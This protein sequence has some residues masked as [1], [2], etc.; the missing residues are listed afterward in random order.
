MAVKNEC[1]QRRTNNCSRTPIPYLYSMPV[2]SSGF[3][4]GI[5]VLLSA[6]KASLRNKVLA[7]V[8]NDVALTIHGIPVRLALQQQGFRLVKLFA[9]EHGLSAT[10]ADGV[11][12][13][14][15][16]DALTGLPVIS[17]YSEKLMP[18]EEDLKDVDMVLYDIPDV[19]SRFYTYLWTLTYV[20]EAC[21]QYHKPLMVLD[22]PNPIGAD[23][24][25][26]EGPLLDESH[27]SSFIGRWCIPIRHSCTTGELSRYFADTKLAGLELTVIP[28][29][30]WHRLHDLEDAQLTFSP[31]SP[32]IRNL[33]TAMLYPGTCLWEGVNVHEGRGT[34]HPFQ[35]M[36]AP[37]INGSALAQALECR[38]LPGVRFEAVHF[39]PASGRYAGE[40]CSGIRC[41]ITDKSSF[42]PVHSGIVILQTLATL[43]PDVLAEATYPTR[44]HPAGTGHLNRLLGL[45]D[46]FRRICTPQPIDTTVPLWAAEISPYLLY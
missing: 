30:G 13:P 35:Q 26:A 8:T 5:D 17:L 40:A 37:W 24:R 6:A 2:V 20:M 4:Y 38:S 7:L 45:P 22:R 23:L 12:Q 32:A 14:H 33:T 19:G 43:Y 3:R 44:A 16:R 11:F 15:G 25:K 42:R 46:S 39:V 18:S 21:R 28:C 1:G 31:T 41:R 9:P 27:C 10:G 29:K 36:G 34:E